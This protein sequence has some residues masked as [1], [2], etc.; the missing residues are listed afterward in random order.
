MT[1]VLVYFFD[2]KDVDTRIHDTFELISKLKIDFASR[3]LYNFFLIVYGNCSCGVSAWCIDSS[4]IYDS[5][6]NNAILLKVQGMYMGCYVFESLLQSTLQCFYDQPCFS[7]LTATM[8]T[9]IRPNATILNAS[10]ASHYSR[11]STVGELLKELMVEEWNWTMMYERYYETCAPSECRYTVKTR[12]DII[13]IVT[14]VIG[15]VGGLVAALKSIVPM[16][17][18]LIRKKKTQASPKAGKISYSCVNYS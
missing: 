3:L 17:V 8:S 13:Y 12:N 1:N 10:V 2:G 4:Y 18:K 15:L 14:A 6:N 9:T 16:P 11:T 5:Q 7:N